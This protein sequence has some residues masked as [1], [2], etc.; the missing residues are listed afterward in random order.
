[1]RLRRHS[2]QAEDVHIDLA[3]MLDFFTNLL[4]F[5]IISAAFVTQAGI[6]VKQPTAKTAQTLNNPAIIV[7]ISAKGEVYVNKQHSDIRLLRNAIEALR[8][9]HPKS[10]VL[11][12][13]D[14]D[15]RGGLI[16]EAMDAARQAGVANIA[17]SAV[18][19][20]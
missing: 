13:A 7:A 6:T 8:Q 18:R 3:P 9:Q 1:M 20:Q 2:T 15:A 11:I 5:F 14:R 17:I 4:I 12:E 16:V 10:P 19:P